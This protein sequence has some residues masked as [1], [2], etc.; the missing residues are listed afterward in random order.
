[1]GIIYV[2]FRNLGDFD[3]LFILL[4]DVQ[5]RKLNCMFFVF[6]CYNILLNDK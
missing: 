4:S 6:E 5:Q 1:M 2:N 3:L